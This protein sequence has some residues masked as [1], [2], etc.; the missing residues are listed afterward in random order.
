MAGGMFCAAAVTLGILYKLELEE[1]R[2]HLVEI[3][4]GQARFMEAVAR[5]DAIHSQGDHPGGARKATLSKIAAAHEHYPGFGETGELVVAQRKGD[6]I[7]FLFPYRHGDGSDPDPISWK[8]ELAEPMRLA[9]SGQEGTLIGVDYRGERVLAAYHPVTGL[10]L[11]VVAKADLAEIRAPFVMAAL[12]AGGVTVLLVLVGAGVTLRVTD[13]LVRKLQKSEENLATTLQSIGD[14]VIVTDAQGGV[15]RMNPVAERL[16]G[17]TLSEALRRPVEH[18]LHIV[19]EDT[20]EPVKAPVYDVLDEGSVIE[21]ANHSVLISKD[22]REYSIAD[23]AAPIRNAGGHL[24]GVVMV[25]RDVTEGRRKKQAL[26][27][28]SVEMESNNEELEAQHERVQAQRQELLTVN[29]ELTGARRAAETANQTKSEFLANM[30]HE[31]RTPMTS[32]LGFTENL[33]DSDQSE[34]EKLNAIY[35]IR[36]NGESLLSIINDILDLSKIEAGKMAVEHIECEPCRIIAEVASLMRV[37]AEER[38]LRFSVEY[39]GVI[40]E[41]ILSDPARLRQILINLIANAIKFTEVG[42]VRL[43]TSFVN[44]NDESR[45][46]GGRHLQFDVIDTGRGMTEEQVARLFQPFVQADTSTTREFGGTGLGLTISKRFAEMLG[47]GIAV[48]ETE[49]DVGTTVRATVATGP[50]EGVRMLDDPM[51]ATV[52]ADAAHTD[53]RI[54]RSDL[55]GCRILLAED[56][57][58]NQRLISLF[59]KKAGAD[60]TVEENG[61]LAVEKALAAMNRRREGDPERPFDIILMDI[62]MPVMDGYEATS[63]LR[64]KGYTGPIIA[65]TAHAMASDREKCIKAGCNDYASKPI[66]RKKLI[67]AIQ[68][69]WVGAEAVSVAAT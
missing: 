40:P 33:L 62:Q 68:Q 17:W 8:S 29:K 22:G 39:V 11:G 34:S 45:S 54:E 16:T 61:K 32:I 4:R 31:I 14:A 66:N 50:L 15:T 55:E 24:I 21:P 60:V 30:S 43:V 28:Y 18:V 25:F 12:T 53:A 44:D 36:R 37:R 13:P 52:V 65:L 10:N 69:H 9:L 42:G 46:C 35:T 59:L 19:N 23:S 56:G 58:D 57:V 51:S 6:Q 47:G 7:V 2:D 48:V 1:Q 67:E 27:A 38:D 64:R 3:A 5:F 49:V 63:L 26:Q 20:R 41:T